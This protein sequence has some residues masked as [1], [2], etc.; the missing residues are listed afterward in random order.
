MHHFPT[1]LSSTVNLVLQSKINRHSLIATQESHIM[2]TR[3]VSFFRPPK[4]ESSDSASGNSDKLSPEVAS[5][6]EIPPLAPATRKSA[7]DIGFRPLLSIFSKDKTDLDAIATQPSVFDEPSTLE[8]YR[9]PPKYES[10]HRFDPL[11]R[12]TWREEKVPPILVPLS[13]NLTP[14]PRRLVARSTGALCCGRAS[15][16]SHWT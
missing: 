12:W 9:P 3:L 8:A 11:E 15:C 2:S 7:N 16:S 5:I 10:V 14:H 6:H 13:W 1:F 4:Q